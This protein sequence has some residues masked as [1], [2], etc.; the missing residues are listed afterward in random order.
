MLIQVRLSFREFKA[1][2]SCGAKP[3]IH[4]VYVWVV[5]CKSMNGSARKN[6]RQLEHEDRG[7]ELTLLKS[8]FLS[9]DS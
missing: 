6:N 9:K 4:L 5:A 3:I 7:D 1:D 8:L 2:A